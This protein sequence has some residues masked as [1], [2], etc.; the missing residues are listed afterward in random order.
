MNLATGTLLFFGFIL[1]A[2]GAISK[3]MGVSLLAPF[4]KSYLGY[5]IAANSCL[6]LALAID[7]FQK[8]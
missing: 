5:F 8:D 6:L 3:F 7:K 1:M 4:V 2:T